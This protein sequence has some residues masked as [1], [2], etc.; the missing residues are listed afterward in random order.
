LDKINLK[1]KFVNY[2]GKIMKE[3][4]FCENNFN[5]GTDNT[6]S[7]LIDNYPDI[8]VIV[9]SCLGNCGECAPGPFALVNNELIVG[10]TVDDLYEKIKETM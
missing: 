9:E 7:K 6:V 8:K 2:G 3:V 10:D 1:R 4:K 5:H